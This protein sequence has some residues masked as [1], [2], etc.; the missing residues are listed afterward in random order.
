M[1]NY[2]P[3]KNL[4]ASGNLRILTETF[5]LPAGLRMMKRS[6]RNLGKVLFLPNIL[7]NIYGVAAYTSPPMVISTDCSFLAKSIFFKQERASSNK[8][9]VTV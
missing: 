3:L 4:C 9:R 8:Q 7:R 2:V 5:W 1:E 6:Q